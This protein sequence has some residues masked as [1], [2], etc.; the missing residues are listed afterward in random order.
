VLVS[1]G[2]ANAATAE[3]NFFWDESNNR[4]G[5]YNSAPAYTLDVNGTIGNSS[6]NL[7]IN[8]NAGSANIL[9]TGSIIPTTDNTYDLG[10]PGS[11]FRALYLAA[12]TIYIGKGKISADANG[13]MFMTNLASTQTYMGSGTKINVAS[14]TGT[15]LTPSTSPAITAATYGYYYNISN[16]RFN[17]LTLPTSYSGD[18]GSYWVLRNNTQSYLNI[19][20]TY[21][22]SSGGSGTGVITIPPANSITV[23]FTSS[24][25]GSGSYT[26]F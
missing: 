26:F 15:S 13:N 2:S 24:G 9:V 16:S 21:T 8:A 3:T 7:G 1:N 17:T 22:G 6:G 10:A 5:V 4:L 18:T 11:T 12:S 19:T 25:Q 23:A 20:V 14:V